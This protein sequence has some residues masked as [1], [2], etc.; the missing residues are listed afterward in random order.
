MGVDPIGHP[1]RVPSADGH[2]ECSSEVLLRRRLWR[3]HLWWT[4]H[5]WYMVEC[6]CESYF[7]SCA[8]L[9]S[10]SK[11]ELPNCEIFPHSYLPLHFWLDKGLVTRRVKKYPMILR[12]AW[13]PR[14]IRNASGNGGG[15][16]I[17][18]MPIVGHKCLYKTKFLHMLNI[19]WRSIGP[20]Q[21]LC[22]REGRV[23]ALQTRSISEGFEEGFPKLEATFEIWRGS[24]L[25]RQC[26]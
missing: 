13:L 4:K 12:P 19:D 21:S 24:P 26:Q 16:L 2:V 14:Q 23:C 20:D 15:V 7:C 22:C 3:T 5:G 6:W 9:I 1:W 11:S 10:F 8:V 17:G 25:R 18:Y